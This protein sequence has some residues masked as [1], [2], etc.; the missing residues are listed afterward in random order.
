MPRCLFER[1]SLRNLELESRRLDFNTP[2][3]RP[4]LKLGP[5]KSDLRSLH[6]LSLTYVDFLDGPLD[7]ADIFS[8]SLFRSLEKLTINY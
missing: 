2:I 6:T 1:D 4:H 7:A 5:A 3:T 8:S